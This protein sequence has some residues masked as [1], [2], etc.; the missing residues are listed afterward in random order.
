MSY[1]VYKSFF[2][3]EMSTP[4]GTAKPAGTSNV[5]KFGSFFTQSFPEV[6]PEEITVKF[7]DV[8]GVDE[9]KLE[10]Q[11]IVDYLKDPEKYTRLGNLV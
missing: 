10:L 11:E 8:K 3:G 7:T 9:A 5:P 1:L 4:D 6:K 2:P